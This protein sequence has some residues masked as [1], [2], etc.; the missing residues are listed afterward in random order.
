MKPQEENMKPYEGKHETSRG[1]SKEENMKP[2]EG[3]HETSC[4]ASS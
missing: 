2:Y 4:S 3:K 1:N